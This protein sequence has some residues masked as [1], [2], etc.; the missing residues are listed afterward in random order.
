MRA[1]VLVASALACSACVHETVQFQA[2]PH[3]QAIVR[4]GQ[5]ALISQQQNSVVMIRPA[6]RRLA[7]GERPVFVVGVRNLT[8]K[9]LNFS[10]RDIAVTQVT[11][12]ESV[13]MKVFSYDELVE[14]EQTRQVVTAL[15]IGAA[16]G[17][18]TALASRAGYRTRTTTENAPSGTRVYQSTSFSPSRAATAQRSALRLGGRM[19]DAAIREGDS[20]LKALEREVIKDNTLLPGEWYGG[21][22]HVQPP[23]EAAD[24]ATPKRYSIAMKIG[25]DTHSIDVTQ[26]SAK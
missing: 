11:G 7:G 26:A 2:R 25:P 18:N 22:L 5:S 16:A 23:A 10:V 15:L 14:E 6:Q 12:A 19:V 8:G 24:A 4:D 20:N 3:Q 9:P 13:A 17:A 1:L 21:T